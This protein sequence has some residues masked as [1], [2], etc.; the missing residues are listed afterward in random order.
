[1]RSRF[2]SWSQRLAG[3]RSP[4]T[5]QLSSPRAIRS[6]REEVAL[7]VDSSITWGKCDARQILNCA[8]A[9]QAA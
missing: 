6:H 3:Q 2:P 7:R 5:Y 8:R 1:M 9:A 4:D